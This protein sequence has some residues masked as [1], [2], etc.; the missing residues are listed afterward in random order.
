MRPISFLHFVSKGY[1][2]ISYGDSLKTPSLKDGDKVVP[3]QVMKT[4]SKDSP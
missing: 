1:K 3:P 2:D 4:P